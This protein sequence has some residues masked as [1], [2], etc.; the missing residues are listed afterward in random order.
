MQTVRQPRV[1]VPVWWLLGC[2]LLVEALHEV[3]G[4]GSPDAALGLGLEAFLLVAA[5]AL[6]L[7]RVV[8]EPRGRRPWLWIGTGLGCWAFG[9]VLWDILYSGDAN[10]PYPSVADAFWLAWYPLTVVG[11]VLLVRDRVRG[12]ELHRWMDGVAVAL[13]VMTPA[14][15]LIVQPVA[16]RSSDNRLTTIVDFSYPILD[17][18]LI[19]GI[20]G[21]CGL[22]AWRPGRVW[23][24]LVLGCGLIALADGVFSVQQARGFLLDGDYDFVWSLGAL[25]IA[26]AA[27][28][29]PPADGDRLEVYGW[30]AIALPVAAQIFA[31]AIQVYAFFHEVG[32]SE[33]VVTLIVLIV[34]T[35]QIIVSRP[36]APVGR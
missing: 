10:P 32:N 5:T 3:F 18:L 13:V 16:S 14:V 29:S 7:G 19:G 17:V 15:A 12:F 28:A 27:W 8:Q 20:L 1:L 25:L 21:V 23:V 34:A 24:L 30:R 22:L 36:R 4:L 2:L 33:R 11:L 31:A 26:A 6:C 9:T 35:V